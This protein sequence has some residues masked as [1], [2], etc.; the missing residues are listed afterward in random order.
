LAIGVLIGLINGFLIGILKANSII[1]TIGMLSIFEVIAW[2]Y[3]KKRFISV[4]SNNPFLEIGK[5]FIYKIPIPVIIFIILAIVSYIILSK[6]TV[7]KYV[8]ATGADDEIAWVVGIKTKKV[9]LL[10]FIISGVFCSIAGIILASRMGGSQAF[11]GSFYLFD[12]ITAVILGGAS[13]SGGKGSIGKTIA[14]VLVVG[15]LA[16]ILVY[17]GYSWASQQFFKGL[18][19][20]LAILINTFLNVDKT[21]TQYE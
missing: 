4:S 2:V 18:L 11:T 9:R 10:T 19:L 1:I 5:G 17:T 7:G 13:L 3:G 20:I 8:Y 16:N 6:T 12:A 14:G 15:I 21:R